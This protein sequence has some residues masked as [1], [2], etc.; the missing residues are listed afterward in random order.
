MVA[1]EVVTVTTQPEEMAVTPEL[2]GKTTQPG[3]VVVTPRVVAVTLNVSSLPP[4]VSPSPQPTQPEEVVVGT[5]QPEEVVTPEM[6]V[7][8]TQ[9]GVVE[10]PGMTVTPPVTTCPFNGGRVTPVGTSCPR[11]L[12]SPTLRAYNVTAH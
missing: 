7:L 5:A 3:E 1:P 8:T 2:V 6:V 4:H 9:L 10:L 11:L 12:P